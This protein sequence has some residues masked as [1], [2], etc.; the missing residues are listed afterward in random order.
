MI[1]HKLLHRRFMFDT[2]ALVAALTPGSKELDAHRFAELFDA[3]LSHGRTLLIAAPS[4]AELLRKPETN[5]LPRRAGI[6]VVPFD[7]RAARTLAER[8]PLA[9]ITQAKLSGAPSNYIKYD[10]MIVACAIRHHADCLVT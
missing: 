1:D 5:D 10:A 8:L 9:A 2:T 3:I 4:L 7:S 6:I